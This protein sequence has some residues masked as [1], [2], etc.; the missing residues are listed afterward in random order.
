LT[1]SVET[2]YLRDGG[3]VFKERLLDAK[4][5]LTRYMVRNETFSSRTMYLFG[6][7]ALN[8]EHMLVSKAIDCARSMGC[9][10]HG[11]VVDGVMVTGEEAQLWA[12][13]QKAREEVRADGTAY[14]RIKQD[15]NCVDILHTAMKNPMLPK[16]VIP[17]ASPHR[18]SEF[19]CGNLK[20]RFKSTAI[21]AH[22]YEP[23]FM[24]P[25]VW[26]ELS[27]DS[28][29]GSCDAND[30][31]QEEAAK[32]IFKRGSACVIGA[33]GTGKSELVKHLV[34]LYEKAGIRVD[35]IAFT[36]VQA[37]NCGGSTVLHDMHQ[38]P[39]CKRRVVIIDE[40]GQVGLNYW[41]VLNSYRVAG[42]CNLVVLGDFAGQLPPITDQGNFDL[43][44]QFP[45]SDFMHDICSGFRVNLRKFRRRN[46]R[47]D[48]TPIPADYAHFTTTLSLYPSLIDD[49]AAL[50]GGA[51]QKV[52]ASYPV[53][54]REAATHLVVTNVQRLRL[55]AHF[56]EVH[57]KRHVST[58]VRVRRREPEMPVAAYL[59]GIVL[60]AVLT[61]RTPAYSLGNALRYRVLTVDG[62]STLAL[63]D[64]KGRT[65]SEMVPAKL[66]GKWAPIQDVNLVDPAQAGCNPCHNV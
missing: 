11:C 49:E 56:N 54:G 4:T 8:T 42:G 43:W 21:G 53:T 41:G 47:P 30:T 36:H 34:A 19:T 40:A 55:N 65:G 45:S 9:T 46:F 20:S 6:L 26:E 63:I 25:R 7:C 35:I 33:G 29:V 64:D 17:V 18:P 1:V 48:G 38:N 66:E 23:R 61:E 14:F 37:Q 50:F 51:L 24:Y 16:V 62:D 59:G 58:F 5:G 15:D 27:E 57:A 52:R 10:V 3:E 32:A 13:R 60:Q 28:G 2:T 22:L 31:F 44:K 39:R 12:L